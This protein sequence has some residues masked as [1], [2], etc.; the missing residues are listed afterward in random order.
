MCLAAGSLLGALLVQVDQSRA[1]APT[2]GRSSQAPVGRG[3]LAAAAMG[4]AVAGMYAVSAALYFK[5]GLG[6]PL[7][8]ALYPAVG[9]AVIAVVIAGIA[10][11]RWRVP[12][13]GWDAFLA[14]PAGAVVAGAAGMVLVQYAMTERRP[15]SPAVLVPEAGRVGGLLLGVAVAYAVAGV[16][17]LRLLIAVPVAVFMA[18]IV[19]S[20]STGILAVIVVVAVLWWWVR[21]LVDLVRSPIRGRDHAY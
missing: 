12:V 5:T 8:W 11:R 13:Q 19:S 4:V 15:S 20:R 17:L 14:F 2:A 1:G 6:S 7:R 18:V 9:V 3:V 21:R 10:F 16:W